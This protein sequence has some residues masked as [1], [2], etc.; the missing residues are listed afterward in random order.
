[1]TDAISIGADAWAFGPEGRVGM[2]ERLRP[3]GMVAGLLAAIG[4]AAGIGFVS[5][6][7]VAGTDDA[8]PQPVSV[9]SGADTEVAAV[10]PAPEPLQITELRLTDAVDAATGEPGRSSRT[11]SI[12]DPVR[13]W[14]SFEAADGSESLTAVWFRGERKVAKLEA[15][16]P[17][18]ASQMVFPL[19]EVAADQ[20]GFY[21]V[22][23]RSHG[24]VLVSEPFEV[25]P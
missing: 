25:T 22:E 18:A 19:P 7:M 12:G 23:V 5:F 1:M 3:F 24:D 15:P 14:L 13:L 11:F 21:R 4:L 20:A 9:E 17:G 6:V 10:V 16:L 2:G 8:A